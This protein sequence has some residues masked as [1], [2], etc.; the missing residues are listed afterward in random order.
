M[1]REIILGHPVDKSVVTH[2][3][4]WVYWN[5]ESKDACIELVRDGRADHW[6]CDDGMP[7]ACKKISFE[8][9]EALDEGGRVALNLL[10]QMNIQGSDK[11]LA[12]WNN[13]ITNI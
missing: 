7:L 6:A 1:L 4:L 2:S 3:G 12:L 5:A 13:L 10:L 8:E 9:V 11:D